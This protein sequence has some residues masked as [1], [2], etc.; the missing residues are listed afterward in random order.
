M[1][2][3]P[4]DLGAE[5]YQ[6]CLVSLTATQ[7]QTQQVLCLPGDTADLEEQEGPSSWHSHPG[8]SLAAPRSEELT[9]SF[10]DTVLIGSLP[11]CLPDGPILLCPAQNSHVLDEWN[12]DSWSNESRH[13]TE[14]FLQNQSLCGDR[15]QGSLESLLWT[16]DEEI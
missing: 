8:Q 16:P 13:S 11:M 3:N 4:E 5:V 10:T 1:G 7:S 2:A 15:N 6:T 12:V 9:V 14:S